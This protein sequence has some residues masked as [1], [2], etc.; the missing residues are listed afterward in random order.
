MNYDINETLIIYPKENGSIVV[1][2]PSGEL[3]LEITAKKDVPANT[4]YLFIN[5]SDLP[6]NWDNYFDAWEADFSSP[7]GYGSHE[8]GEGTNMVVLNYD[9]T[10]NVAVIRDNTTNEIIYLNGEWSPNDNN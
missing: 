6:E 4:P 10:G 7:D 2:T 3:S 9:E 8:Y 5:K 1:L